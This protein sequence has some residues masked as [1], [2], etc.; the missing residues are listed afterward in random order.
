MTDHTGPPPTPD[1]TAAPDPTTL[2]SEILD[3]V[4]SLAANLE[5]PQVLTKFVEACAELTGSPY[6]AINVLDKTGVSTK[7]VQIGVDPHTAGLMP[8]PP[9]SHGVLRKIPDRGTLRLEDLTQDPWF[10]G[11]P[12]GHPPM[13]SFLGTTI[14]IG[15]EIFGYLYLAEKPG[16]FQPEDDQIV[17]ALAAAAGVA[18]QNAQLYDLAA[19]RERWLRAGQELTTLLLSGE[20][21][22]ESIL[23]E[24]ASTS[25]DIADADTAGLVL[26]GMGGGLFFE[27]VE[28]WEANKIIGLEVPENGVA[29]SA[30]KSGWGTLLDLSTA[31]GIMV[32][33]MRMFGPALYAPLGT[34]DDP[35]GVLVLLRR[36]GSKPF[37]E[38]DLATA[39]TFASQAAIAMLLE[40]ARQVQAAAEL[41]DERERIA[42]D[43]HD[44]AIQQLFATGMQLETI[45]RRAERGVHPGELV[46]V[47]EDALTNVDSTVREIRSIVHALHDP[48]SATGLVERLRREA[49]L[50]R[51]GLSFAPS[52]VVTLDDYTIGSTVV[53]G[54]MVDDTGIIDDFITAPLSDDVVAVVREGLAN[55]ARHA[56]ASSVRVLVAVQSIHTDA[57]PGVASA[58]EVTIE[59]TDDGVG[60]AERSKRSSGTGN[61][62]SRARQHKGGFT[63]TPNTDGPG[64]TM[65]W[66]APIP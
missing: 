49:S 50:A 65:T 12:D 29:G 40:S 9:G 36:I 19:R 46:H 51:T 60:L 16:G 33:T 27:I 35:V 54:D 41:S 13:H 42:R 6:A 64:T 1:Q 31:P 59:V 10:E 56:R 26:P 53:G 17:E 47:V 11:F 30:L 37:D 28:G 66:T 20:K 57:I 58:G 14:R 18:I 55:A 24:I 63:L 7:F 34:S 2:S 32:P 8:H 15:E 52:L 43:L 5:L 21:D 44:L 61:L 25:R 39:E 48:D 3:A 4:L 38:S 62:A 23:E 45:R 22:E